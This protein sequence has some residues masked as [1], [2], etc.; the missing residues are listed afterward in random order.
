MSRAFYVW[1]TVL[2]DAYTDLLVAKLVR[3][4]YSISPAAED[5]TI[6]TPGPYSSLISL[7]VLLS[8]NAK[9]KDKAIHAAEFH[10]E[11][12]TIFGEFKGLFYSMVVQESGGKN[13]TCWSGGNM[14]KPPRKEPTRFDKVHEDEKAAE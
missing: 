8:D 5:G 1:I 14:P 6:S 12:K 2:T 3:R 10:D 7:H 11:L 13:T 9:V 4:G